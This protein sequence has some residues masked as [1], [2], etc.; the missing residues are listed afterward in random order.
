M[1]AESIVK[2]S[3]AKSYDVVVAG[4]G[5][6]GIVSAVSAAR[7]GARVLL[8]ERQGCL[9]GTATTG[10]VAQYIGFYNGDTKAVWGIP[11]EILERIVEAGGSQG[12]GTYTMAEA[13]ANPLTVHHFPFNPEIVKIVLDELAAESAIDLLFHASV[14]DVAMHGTALTGLSVET[15]GG[16]RQYIG[17]VIIDATGDATVAHL[18]GA[19]MLPSE[20]DGERQPNTLCFRLSNVDVPRFRAI[21]RDIKRKMVLGGLERGEL[22]WESLSF[23]STPGNT[24]AI[25][26]MSRIKGKDALDE[27]DASDQERIG[28][29]QIKSIVKFLQREVPGFEKAILASIAPR[30]GVRETRRIKGQYTLTAD[31]ILENRTFADVMA[32]GVGPMDI[33]DSNGTGIALSMPPTPFQIPMRC[34]IPE[35]VDGLIV[36]GRAIS[37]TREANGGARHMG[38][39]MALGHA[40]GAMAAISMRHANS[41][42][43]LPAGLVQEALARQGASLNSTECQTRTVAMGRYLR[44]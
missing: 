21:P 28:R 40:A 43:V 38:T 19:P 6:S 25:C 10:Y 15:I 5:T 13:A 35:G 14:V 29:A 27:T 37:A 8:L 7:L 26:L 1:T 41:L 17:K 12:F 32:L 16:R 34:L 42:S 31:D 44:A 2:A 20:S 18:A 39:A 30:V 22:F 23:V 3:E 33:H 24:D 9:G 36:T 4:G 11:D